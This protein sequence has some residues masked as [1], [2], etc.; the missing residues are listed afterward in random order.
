MQWLMTFVATPLRR[1]HILMTNGTRRMI[2]SFQ[3]PQL[4]ATKIGDGKLVAYCKGGNRDTRRKAI[5]IACVIAAAFDRPQRLAK[6][7]KFEYNGE[8]KMILEKLRAEC[9]GV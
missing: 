5:C 8:F 4:R 9:H 3:E 7:R 1:M 6:I 2:C